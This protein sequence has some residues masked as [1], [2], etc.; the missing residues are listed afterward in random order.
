[1]TVK[2]NLNSKTSSDLYRRPDVLHDPVDKDLCYFICTSHSSYKK[3]IIEKQQIRK[4]DAVNRGIKVLID[5][6]FC[7]YFATSLPFNL[8]HCN[9]T[10]IQINN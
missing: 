7:R 4:K 8:L 6:C 3:R 5:I 2:Y 9:E 1:M 10:K